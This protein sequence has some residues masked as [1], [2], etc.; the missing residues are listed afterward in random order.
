MPIATKR[1]KL[2]N[3]LLFLER[4]ITN[5][6]TIPNVPVNIAKVFSKTNNDSFLWL[7]QLQK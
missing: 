4:A 1:K 7:I 5:N 6:V 2:I 3:L